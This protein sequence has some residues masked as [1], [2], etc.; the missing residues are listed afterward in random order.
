M[1]NKPTPVQPISPAVETDSWTVF[2]TALD[3]AI[4]KIQ[5][6]HFRVPRYE[7]E[8]AWRERVYCYELYHLLRCRLPKDFPYTLHGEID[9]IGHEAIVQHFGKIKRPNPDFVL[10]NPGDM[11]I[12]ANLVIV[13]VKRSDADLKLIKQDRWKTRKFIKHVGYQHG[14]I[15]FFGE[16]TPPDLSRLGGIE[17]I[18]HKAVGQKPIQ[19]NKGKFS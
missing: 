17:A 14:V 1:N 5:P 12:E 8:S 2:R 7:E 3:E 16:K 11:G 13:E 9:K 19:S 15:L 10:H 18:W 6:S 4:E